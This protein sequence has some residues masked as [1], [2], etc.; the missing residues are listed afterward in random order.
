MT[1]TFLT[2]FRYGN[3]QKFD[4]VLKGEHYTYSNTFKLIKRKKDK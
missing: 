2:T 1:I 3:G 4:Y